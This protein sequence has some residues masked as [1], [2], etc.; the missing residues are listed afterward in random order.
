MLVG[1]ER[2]VLRLGTSAEYIGSLL[3]EQRDQ[4]L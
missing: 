2:L 4:N 1:K 3:T